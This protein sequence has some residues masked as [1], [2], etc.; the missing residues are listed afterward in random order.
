MLSPQL[1]RLACEEKRSAK[2]LSAIS[3]SGDAAFACDRGETF[4]MIAAGVI[5]SDA[6]SFA[7]STPACRG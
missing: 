7:S 1:F 5:A 4:A 2:Q 3:V 6:I